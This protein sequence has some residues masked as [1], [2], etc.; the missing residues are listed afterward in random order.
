MEKLGIDK[1]GILKVSRLTAVDEIHKM[2]PSQGF[3]E[4]NTGQCGFQRRSP[5]KPLLL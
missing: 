2:S 4:V 1:K 3:D 5:G